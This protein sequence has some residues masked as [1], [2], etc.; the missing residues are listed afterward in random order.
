LEI[1]A[2]GLKGNSLRR[3]QRTEK[4][5]PHQF[6]SHGWSRHYVVA[7]ESRLSLNLLLW[8]STIIYDDLLVLRQKPWGGGSRRGV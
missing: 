2:A 1:A 4:R 8:G 5:L 3:P 7:Y 6:V